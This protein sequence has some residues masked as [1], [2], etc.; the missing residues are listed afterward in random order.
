MIAGIA[1]ARQPARINAAP[2]STGF[3]QDRLVLSIWRM[4]V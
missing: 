3:G 4:L 1:H 2:W